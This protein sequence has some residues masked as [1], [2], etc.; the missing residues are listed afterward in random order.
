MKIKRHGAA[1]LGLAAAGTLLLA[2]CGTDN[3]ATTPPAA[4]SSGG[5]S[6]SAATSPIRCP[7]GSVNL[8]LAGSTAQANA[9]SLWAKNYEGQCSGVNINNGLGGSGAGVTQFEAGTVDWAGSD[10]PLSAT[11]QPKADARCKTGPAIDLP[12]VPGPIAVGYNLP[13]VTSLNLSAS[14][15]AG[16]FDGRIKKWND[17][18]VAKDNPG[19]TLPTMGIQTFHRSDSSGTSFNFTN[20]LANEARADWAFGA[21]KQWPA[22]GGQG[23]KGSALVS[24]DVKKTA[25][26]IGYFELSYATQQQIPYAKVSNAAGQFVELTQQNTTNFIGK[27]TVAGTGNDLKL[28]FDY[29]NSD[30]DAYPNV[31]VTYEI[32]C[33]SGNDASKLAALK[34]FLSYAASADGQN[35]IVSQGYVSLPEVVRTKVVSAIDALS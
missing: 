10:F 7:S 31:L 34:D 26:G 3:N 18:A 33:S 23:D 28:N 24:Q 19:V 27:A 12:L 21:N 25:G 35:T 5:S 14:T 32:V 16:I 17:A 1:V 30:S 13:G 20:Y 9:I 2:A 11:D 6:A 8:T 15:L 29:T 22:P 4:A